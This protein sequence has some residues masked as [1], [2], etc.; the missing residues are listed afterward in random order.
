MKN[1]GKDGEI[2]LEV[3]ISF[4]KM[5]IKRTIYGEMYFTK[6]KN[7]VSQKFCFI[8]VELNSPFQI[9]ESFSTTH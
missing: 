6:R 1:C 9:D 4:Y 2:R 7:L 5:T 8:R 3:D